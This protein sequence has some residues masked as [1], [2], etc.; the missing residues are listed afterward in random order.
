MEENAK[1][2]E[3]NELNEIN[4]LKFVE[5]NFRV[6]ENTKTF[7]SNFIEIKNENES[8]EKKKY[9][10]S[11]NLE[12]CVREIQN[13]KEKSSEYLQRVME[14]NSLLGATLSKK[15]EVEEEA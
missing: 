1:E 5:I 2:S 6:N 15:E 3:R 14:S 13:I 12:D 11:I 8:S 4:Q 7:Y 10:K 9:E